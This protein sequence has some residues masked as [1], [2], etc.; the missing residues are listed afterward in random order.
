MSK[1]LRHQ[2]YPMK[3]ADGKL[4]ARHR[5]SGEEHLFF[6]EPRGLLFGTS[7]ECDLVS[8]SA[9]VD[10]QH[11]R[12]FPQGTYIWI[13]TLKSEDGKIEDVALGLLE[14][15]ARSEQFSVVLGEFT[16][17]RCY[18]EVPGGAPRSIDRT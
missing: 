9:D 12:I 3:Y 10:P 1:G 15:D 8:A 13:R 18:K 5:E 17:E 11:A 2:K 6:L 14:S 4:L 16:F 7:S